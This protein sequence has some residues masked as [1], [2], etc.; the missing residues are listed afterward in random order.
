MGEVYS[1]VDRAKV[2]FPQSRIVL[3]GVLR[4]TDVSWQRIGTLND[5]YDWIAKRV[6]V[7]FVEPNSWFEDWD[8]TR[9]GLHINRRGARRLSQ[10]HS[11]V[12]GLGSSGKKRD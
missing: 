1:L 12:G 3:S 5:R 11:R 6:G 2:K 8:F 7:T 10:L 9:D 4:R